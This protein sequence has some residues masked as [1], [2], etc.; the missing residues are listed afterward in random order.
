V[1]ITTG[2]VEPL[3]VPIEVVELGNEVITILV[4]GDVDLDEAGELR[5]VLAEA[6]GHGHRAVIVDL[7]AVHFM[8]SSGMGVL[9]ELGGRLK[10]ED[11]VL[12][13]R[14]CQP[15]VRRAFEVTGLDRHLDVE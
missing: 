1:R 10:G 14:G 2:G 8:G 15:A 5:A 3:L 11:R 6:I 13:I 4:E 9:A 12:M 7:S